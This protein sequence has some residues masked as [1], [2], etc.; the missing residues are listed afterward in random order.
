MVTTP[1]SGEVCS[2]TTVASGGGTTLALSENSSGL[3]LETVALGRASSIAGT[4]SDSASTPATTASE[5][6]R[7]RRHPVVAP[8]ISTLSAISGAGAPSRAGSS[9]CGDPAGGEQHVPQKGQLA[10]RGAGALEPRP[11]RG[12][13]PA[14]GHRADGQ[15]VPS[16]GVA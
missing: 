3:V 6:T 2:A 4:P 10:A 13:G 15:P 8:A 7:L 1:W 16:A 11:Q 14:A 9:A 5:P 12:T